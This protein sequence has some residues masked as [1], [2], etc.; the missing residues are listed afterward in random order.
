[1]LL[2]NEWVE[3]QIKEEIKNYMETNED[4]SMVFQNLWDS[5]KAVIR[6]LFRNRGLPQETRKISN[7]QLNLTPKRARKRT[8]KIQ[9]QKKEGN[10]KIRAEIN[11]IKTKKKIQHINETKS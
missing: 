1:M 6:W 11:Y 4:E 10:K 9:N 7:K 2:N 8:N 3:Q 5:A